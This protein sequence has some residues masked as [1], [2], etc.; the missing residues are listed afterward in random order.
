MIKCNKRKILCFLLFDLASLAREATKDGM[1]G[2][3]RSQAIQLLR[4][5]QERGGEAHD[6]QEEGRWSKLRGSKFLRD[7]VCLVKQFSILLRTRIPVQK[8][9]TLMPGWRS[10]H[11]MQ[12]KQI[13]GEIQEGCTH[14]IVGRLFGH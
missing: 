2:T 4:G 13:F 14:N 12:L 5:K 11:E 7:M 9:I 6:G 8:L 1:G 10:S 3:P